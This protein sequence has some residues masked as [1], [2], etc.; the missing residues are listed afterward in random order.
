MN[1]NTANKAQSKTLTEFCGLDNGAFDRYLEQKDSFL[2]RLD[3]KAEAR[4][5]DALEKKL[6]W[7]A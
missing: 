7:V 2:L 6:C 3:E 4:I 1:D 5:C